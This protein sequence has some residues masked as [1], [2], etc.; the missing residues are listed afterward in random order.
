[1]SAAVDVALTAQAALL[2]AATC[3]GA[4]T[5]APPPQALGYVALFA[6]VLALFLLWRRLW[7]WTAQALLTAAL[8][9]LC[10]WGAAAIRPIVRAVW[11]D[12]ARTAPHGDAQ[13]RDA[14][15]AASAVL[16]LSTALLRWARAPTPLAP[17]LL[18]ALVVVALDADAWDWGAAVAFLL[19]SAL[20][21][22]LARE[23][24]P[25][26]EGVADA[27]ARVW[28]TPA[29]FALVDA[30]LTRPSSSE[31]P[32]DA[33]LLTASAWAPPRPAPRSASVW[34]M[35]RGWSPRLT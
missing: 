14:L 1:M 34:A 20:A 31:E 28:G 33:R 6:P 19:A 17:L 32:V 21:V 7:L 29:A 35:D 3:V 23:T 11:H 12:G 10:A 30:L 15:Y 9:V 24:A 13:Q 18:S 26:A 22:H 4:Y 25:S 27:L 16:L 2:G 5:R 8:C